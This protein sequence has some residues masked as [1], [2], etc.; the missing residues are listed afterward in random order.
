[1]INRVKYILIVAGIIGIVVLGNALD[2]VSRGGAHQ[3]SSQRCAA[4]QD[5]AGANGFPCTATVR[6]Y[7]W[8]IPTFKKYTDVQ[9]TTNGFT[10]PMNDYT[11][12]PSGSPHA[13][14][15]LSVSNIVLLVVA[16][17]IPLGFWRWRLMKDINSTL[18][19]Q[20]RHGGV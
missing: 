6:S 4:G 12:S 3:Y 1:M 19:Y 2:H 9:P 5:L 13:S 15:A 14:G 20:K 10:V 18:D 7:G 16:A 17:S 8:P 11:E